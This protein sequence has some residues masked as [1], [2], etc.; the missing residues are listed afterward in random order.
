MK[1]KKIWLGILVMA[2]VFGMSVVGC[3]DGNGGGNGNGDGGGY[4][5][6][7]G[8][9]TGI[10]CSSLSDGTQCNAQSVC[11]SKFL[12]LTGQGSD[13][14]CTTGCSCAG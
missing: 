13:S 4:G 6:G 10:G 8:G 14:N 12:C 11:S 9:G 3:N 5:G 1:N 7:I 2:L